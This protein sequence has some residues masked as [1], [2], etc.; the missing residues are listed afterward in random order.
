MDEAVCIARSAS[1]IDVV[2]RSDVFQQMARAEIGFVLSYAVA[3]CD[4]GARP[5]AALP[6]EQRPALIEA[7]F[8]VCGFADATGVRAQQ[9]AETILAATSDEDRDAWADAL[10]ALSDESAA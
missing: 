6:A 2:V 1:R 8:E 10:D 5:M 3:L 9:L 4:A 7:L